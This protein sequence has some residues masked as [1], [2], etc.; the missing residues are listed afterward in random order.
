M[1][2][3]AA[4]PIPSATIG[5][6]DLWDRET[7]EKIRT[8]RF[9]NSELNERR[10]K[11]TFPSITLRPLRLISLLLDFSNACLGLAS[12]LTQMTIG[13]HVFLFS[14]V[15]ALAPGE[16]HEPPP[17]IHRLSMAGHFWCRQDGPC[18]FLPLLFIQELA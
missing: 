2:Q 10:G 12:S 3:N 17:W 9:K 6:S 13:Y 5:L 7:R 15:L 11:V 4:P 16:P 8:K 14:E 18:L 1:N